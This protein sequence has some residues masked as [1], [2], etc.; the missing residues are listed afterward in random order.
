MADEPDE[1]LASSDWPEIGRKIRARTPARLLVGRAGASYRTGTQLDLREAHAAA[2]DAVRTEREV[3][4]ATGNL[5]GN[6]QEWFINEHDAGDIN[7]LNR[8]AGSKWTFLRNRRCSRFR[9]T[10]FLSAQEP[11]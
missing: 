2:R 10:G 8:M 4:G 7:E 9:T 5:G 6:R 11:I 1:S 3:G